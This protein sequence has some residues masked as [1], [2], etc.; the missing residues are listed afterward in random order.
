VIDALS[1]RTG[2]APTPAAVLVQYLGF[3][4]APGRREYEIRVRR[5]DQSRQYTLWIARAAFAQRQALLQDGP[6][7][8][9]Q[10]L[11][12]ALADPELPTAD[13]IAVTEGDLAD[14]RETHTRKPR[15]GFSSPRPSEVKPPT[16]ASPA[17]RDQPA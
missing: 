2:A 9:Y 7:I 16:D 3:Q 14:Y 13:C 12:R 4:D 17:T 11:L 10:K 5:G 1:P 15:G 6:D 8:C